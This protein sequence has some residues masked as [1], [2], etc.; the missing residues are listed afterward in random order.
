MMASQRPPYVAA[1]LSGIALSLAAHGQDPI[2]VT[3]RGRAVM[4][5]PVSHVRVS[6]DVL[7]IGADSAMAAASL[8]TH[9][10]K[11]LESLPRLGADPRTIVRGEVR[12]APPDH[13]P[14]ATPRWSNSRPPPGDNLPGLWTATTPVLLRPTYNPPPESAPAVRA[15]AKTRLLQRLTF[16]IALRSGDPAAVVLTLD[17]TETLVRAALCG[18]TSITAHTAVGDGTG[19]PCHGGIGTPRF[20]RICKLSPSETA[21][22][23]TEAV[24]DASRQA[25]SMA[26]DVDG[27]VDAMVFIESLDTSTGTGSGHTVEVESAV[28]VSARFRIRWE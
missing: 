17:D 1:V 8:D 4:R 22:L 16:D 19:R 25:E 23:A 14:P 3:A 11:A 2:I 6:V 28:D 26:E 18:E 13:P 21:S 15:T 5:R 24:A 9:L 20:E 7:G 12:V 10:Q 27:A